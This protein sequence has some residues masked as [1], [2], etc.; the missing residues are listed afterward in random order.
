[1]SKR[2]TESMM[3]EVMAEMEEYKQAELNG[4]LDPIALAFQTLFRSTIEA[5]LLPVDE[6]AANVRRQQYQ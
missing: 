2:I 6:V 3:K 5:S 4:T 1:M